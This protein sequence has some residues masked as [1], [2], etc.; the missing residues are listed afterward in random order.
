MVLC[1][2]SGILIEVG[3]FLLQK[4][5]YLG[6][7]WLKVYQISASLV[8]SELRNASFEAK[9]C[10]PQLECQTLAGLW[11]CGNASFRRRTES[12]ISLL[13]REGGRE[14]GRC[15]SLPPRLKNYAQE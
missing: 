4:L 10:Q 6:R 13:G 2:E 7:L 1:E 5:R 11:L 12:I 3:V 14:R 15:S 8:H 9:K